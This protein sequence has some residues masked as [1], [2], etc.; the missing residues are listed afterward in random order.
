MVYLDH[1]ATTPL[2]PEVLQAMMPYLT[3]EFGN[4]SSVYGLGQR[5]R[6]AIDQARDEV[7]A[8]Y[9]V[10]TKEI[11]FTSGGTEGDNFAVHGIARRNNDRGRHVIT[12]TIEHDAVLRSAEALERDGFEVTRLGVDRFGLVDPDALRQALRPDTILV[13]IMHA[14]NEI[15]TIEPIRELVA[16]TRDHSDA[17]FH[18]DAVQSTGKIPT[19][20]EDLGVDLLSMSA[21]KLHGPKGVGCLVVRSGVRLEPQI[22]GGGHER[23]RRAGTE[24]VAGIVGLAKAVSIARRDL[25]TNTAY[26]TRLR[27]R[28]IA[29]VLDRI[30]RAGLTGHPRQRLPH[31]ASFLFEGVE[32][33]SLLLQL[34]MDGIAASSGSA[35][36]SGSLEPS[37]VILALGYP[38]ER[39]IGSLRLSLGKGNT[40]A[41]IDLVLERL[42]QM[43]ARLRVMAPVSAA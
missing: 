35:C 39:A 10:A 23:N 13:S 8:F 5:A 41:E 33:E 1:S 21:H 11:I 37:H 2:D 15:G 12:S 6:Q 24:N 42:P 29:G 18:T 26:L 20:V 27:D 22:L 30:P 4:A 40:D 16:M 36:T 17:Y 14:N 38:R 34:D 43:V 32:G 3:E 31:H 19:T 28:L 9:R 7:A 25:D